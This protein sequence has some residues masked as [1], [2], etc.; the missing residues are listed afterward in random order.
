[1]SE[2]RLIECKCPNNH[3]I[4]GM[5]YSPEDITSE[6]ILREFPVLVE[7]MIA[8][9]GIR[10][11]CTICNKDVEFHYE[12]VKSKFTTI[13]EAREAVEAEE[14]RNRMIDL[15]SKFVRESGNRFQ[16]LAERHLRN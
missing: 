16:K 9:K 10:R 5:V 1:M 7:S 11:F 13:E 12:D 8:L 3:R 2:I 4:L 14:M 6:D 15:I